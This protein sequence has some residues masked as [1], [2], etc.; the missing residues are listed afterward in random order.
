MSIKPP[1]LIRLFLCGDVMTGRGIDQILPCP[2]D[3][4]LYE[5]HVR[6]AHRYVKL[7]EQINGPIPRAA[8]LDYIWGDALTELNRAAT[9][10]R[11][12]N[13]E[14]SI[15]RSDDHWRG[16]GVNYRMHPSNVGCL[17]AARIDCCCL[18]N[19]HVLDWGYEGLA[20]TLRTLDEAGIAHCGAG[21]DATQAA[22]PAVLDVPGKGRVLIFPYGMTSS[23][24]PPEWEA[25]RHRPGV[26]ML[27][28]ISEE[29][30][31]R[32]ARKM[33]G[34]TRHGDVIVA[35]IHWGENWGHDIRPEEKHFAR[36]LLE[37]GVNVVH[38]HSS[39]HVK[40]IEIHRRRLVLYGCGD[41][42]NDYEG[43][44][45]HEAFRSDLALIHLVTIDAREGTLAELRLLPMRI[46]H[47][48]LNHA[49][50]ADA[51][52]VGA[53]LN[54]LGASTGTCLDLEDH[55]TL[56]A[57]IPLHWLT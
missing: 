55:N 5:S 7:A 23:G 27:T 40:T 32:L 43:I 6:D 37:E 17:T 51:E 4:T 49:S 46:K 41:F 54:W 18:A 29:N 28:D 38:G 34:S 36:C 20:E 56:V 22:A 9:D 52:W 39:H 48:R 13:L 1:E 21:R 45:G 19:N 14:T 31:R 50:K 15:T 30:A 33:T 47:F 8:G 53:M 12:V 26:N 24:I 35:S 3:P 25:T 42:L 11:I 44:S 57:R 2:G 16:K 10:V